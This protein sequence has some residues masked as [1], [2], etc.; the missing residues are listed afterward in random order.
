LHVAYPDRYGIWNNRVVEAFKKLGLLELLNLK[1]KF[2]EYPIINEFLHGLLEEIRTRY[3]LDDSF[4]LW[5]VDII[6]GYIGSNDLQDNSK[7]DETEDEINVVKE[8]YI[9]EILLENW[10][11]IKG[12]KDYELLLSEDEVLSEYILEQVGR[13]D[14]LAKD[15][16]DNSLVIVELKIKLKPSHF[17]QVLMYMGAAK[18]MKLDKELNLKGIKGLILYESIDGKSQ[19]VIKMLRE[20][21]IPI[22]IKKYSLQINVHE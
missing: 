7:S 22:E 10:D 1:G 6:W 21:N 17:S 11:K 15:K 8:R 19:Y 13:V 20:Y 4:G 2:R 5:E 18:N 9:H 3:N 14:I 12:L 16:R